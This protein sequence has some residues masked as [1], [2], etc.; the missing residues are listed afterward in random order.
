MPKNT[1]GII[2]Y[3]NHSKKLIDIINKNS[4]VKN[5]LVYSYKKQKL[6]N[7][8]KNNPCKKVTYTNDLIELKN[9]CYSIFISSPSNTH[10]K[11]L[12]YFK[13]SNKYIFCEKP[14]LINNKQLKIISNYPK[15]LKS[16]IYFNY[17]LLHSKLYKYIKNKKNFDKDLIG[18]S[19]QSSTGIAYLKKFK[20]NW[21]FTSK[22][23]LQ[24]ITGNW[25]VHSIN[26]AINIFGK[27]KKYLISEIGISS[28]K[29]ID[30]CLISI[31]FLNNK[32]AN[33]FLSYACPMT[34]EMTF[35]YSN[36]IL[37][38]QEGKV[39]QFGPRN[40]FDKNGL[41]KKPPKKNFRNLKGDI[42]NKSLENSV[43]YFIEVATKKKNFP[44]YLFNNALETI[45]VFLNFDYQIK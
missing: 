13:N 18:M 16:R 40:C 7:L 9:K 30:T 31:Q 43:E 41:F 36:K 14:G 21:R 28:K 37:K 26:L 15:K 39:F 19:Y 11:Y 12:T 3:R 23:I 34:D 42:S 5:I 8:R 32:T 45:K 10:F 35:I 44:N 22:D 25:G 2:G 17:N 6:S 29:K 38:Y 4:K 20:N 33:I 27:I 1:V 24:R